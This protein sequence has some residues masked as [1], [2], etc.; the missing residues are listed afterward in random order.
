MQFIKTLTHRLKH[1][2]RFKSAIASPPPLPCPGQAC[3]AL[4]K[5]AFNVGLHP[6]EDSH[7]GSN[8]VNDESKRTR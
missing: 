6:R 5:I 4:G 7:S 8:K 2:F 1:S 3:G